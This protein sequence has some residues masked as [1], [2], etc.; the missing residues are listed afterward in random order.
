MHCHAADR[1]A[2]SDTRFR[3]WVPVQYQRIMALPRFGNST[4][5]VFS[6]K[7]CTSAVPVAELKAD[8]LARWPGAL[9]SSMA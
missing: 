7:F 1:A 6:R 2:D 4:C 8:I 5:L 9:Y 3:C